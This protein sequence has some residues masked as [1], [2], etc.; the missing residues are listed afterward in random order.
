MFSIFH[1]VW[2]NYVCLCCTLV[3]F[4]LSTVP[5]H[6]TQ[7]GLINDAILTLKIKKIVEKIKKYADRKDRSK[8]LATML[9]LKQET[10]N[11]LDYKIDV[12]GLL[13]DLEKDFHKKG[14]NIEDFKKFRKIV[15]SKMKR[16]SHRVDYMAD[17][18]AN[19]I[20]YNAEL[21]NLDFILNYSSHKQDEKEIILSAQVEVGLTMALC[22]GL[23]W[24]LGLRIPELEAPGR[25]LTLT[26][27]GMAVQGGAAQIDENRQKK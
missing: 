15:K 16:H 3:T 27:L 7:R 24:F 10:E 8:L 12:N 9:D 2:I 4:S 20:E 5:L 11:Y 26:G 25:W 21:E 6:A 19:G 22:G 23:L 14:G 13:G 1:S 18:L 17:C